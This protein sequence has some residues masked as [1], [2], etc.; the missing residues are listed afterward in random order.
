MSTIY[1]VFTRESV[2]FE[3]H[4]ID[5]RSGG[6]STRLCHLIIIITVESWFYFCIQRGGNDTART[7][8]NEI[9][10]RR[11]TN[12][13]ACSTRW[14]LGFTPHVAFPKGELFFEDIELFEI[15]KMISTDCLE[16]ST[17]WVHLAASK[18]ASHCD[19][20]IVGEWR[21]QGEVLTV[22]K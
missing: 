18:S 16:Y 11:V 8:T 15:P 19:G 4:F 10:S 17:K 21:V 2:A 5:R 7:C 1:N 6:T 9:E 14:A 20:F 22:V 3:W 13:N 12:S